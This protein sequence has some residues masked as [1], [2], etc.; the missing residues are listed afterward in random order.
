MQLLEGWQP[1][2]AVPTM[3]DPQLVAIYRHATGT[4]AERRK[5][6]AYL[7]KGDS[8]KALEHFDLALTFSPDD[9]VAWLGR[10]DALMDMGD[11]E[12][13]ESLLREVVDRGEG[14]L[15]ALVRLA[16]GADLLIHEATGAHTGHSAP[17]QAAEIAR[18]AGVARLALIHYPV[19][20]VNL[21]DWRL[22]AAEFPGPV[23]LARDGNSYLL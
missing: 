8:S 23:E 19:R 4:I 22:A 9:A 10:V 20:G 15:P 14:G 7:R 2:R 11:Y 13:C 3:R 1:N 21:E 18:E 5:G 12:Q 16:L 6:L 17:A